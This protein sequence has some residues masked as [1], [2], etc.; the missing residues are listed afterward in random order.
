MS[1]LPDGFRCINLND[2]VNIVRSPESDFDPE[3]KTIG[4]LFTEQAKKW[5]DYPALVTSTGVQYTYKQYYDISKQFA[6]SL[7]SIG[8]KS[9]EPVAMIGYNSV[10]WFFSLHGS[11]L[12]GA[13]TTGIYSTNGPSACEY[14]LQHSES[15]VILCQGGKQLDKIL[16]IRAN[17]PHLKAIVVYW[18]EDGFK[19]APDDEFAKVYKW[20]EFLECGKNV[21]EEQFLERYNAVKPN[22]CATLI[23]TSGTTGNPKGVMCSHD[24][25]TFNARGIIPRIGFQDGDR[26][27]SFLPLNHIAA[28]YVD[29]MIPAYTRVCVYMTRPD[30]LKGTLTDTMKK[31]RPTV[32]VAVPRVYEK[33]MEKLKDVFSHASCVKK[34]LINWARGKGTES[35]LRRQYGKPYVEPFGYGIAKKI[36]FDKIKESL[37]FGAIRFIIVA[38]APVTEETQLFFASLDLPLYDVLG[39]SEGTAPVFANGYINQTWKLRSCGRPMPGT[40]GRIDPNTHEIQ[41]KGRFVMMGYLKMETETLQTIDDE[42]WLHTGDMGR[43][44]NDGFFYVTGRIKELIVTAGG[45]NI[46]PVLIETKIMELSN[47]FANVVVVGD[48]KKYLSCLISLKTNANPLNGEPTDKLAPASLREA[49]L[50]GSTATTVQEAQNCPKFKAYIDGII[51]RYN[52]IAVSRAQNIRKWC[53]LDR[54]LSLGNDELTATLKLKR[55]IVHK[56]FRDVIESMYAEN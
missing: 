49:A 34:C 12:C 39:Q 21:E 16:S 10:E 11:W 18:P 23:Y 4:E 28:Q 5:A 50:I 1:Q 31:A 26:F 54:D 35:C 43:K 13:V 41:Y 7:I 51:S 44:D 47:C 19:T 14:V 25:C 20:D 2:T 52:E 37:G 38:A 32:L 48:K 36:L 40:E 46:P 8:V 6:K 53:I 9:F 24:G 30:A 56:N 22:Q 55:D 15:R 17:L 3:P 45:E 29:A 33:M 27:V 42:G